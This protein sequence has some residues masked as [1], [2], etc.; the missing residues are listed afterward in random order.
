HTLSVESVTFSPDGKT[1]LSASQ[2]RTL[3][4][5]EVASGTSLRTFSGNTNAVH[6]VA[7]S[8]DGKTALSASADTTLRLW[9][10]PSEADVIA[11]V[12]ANRYVAQLPCAMRAQ[13]GIAPLCAAD[14]TQ[15]P[16]P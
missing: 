5:W 8:P 2:D 11:F 6:S 3:R 15:T 9:A 12:R 7:F 4:L 10:I 14:A 13:Y 16:T 1:A